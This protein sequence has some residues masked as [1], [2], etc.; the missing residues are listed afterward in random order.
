MNKT[1][2]SPCYILILLFLESLA[3]SNGYG[4]NPRWETNKRTPSRPAAD[5]NG[6]IKRCSS[7]ASFIQTATTGAAAFLLC[8][9]SAA[10]AK[11]ELLT[12]ADKLQAGFD[13]LNKE[14]SSIDRV[15]TK[16]AKKVDRAVTRKSAP[17]TKKIDKEVKKA[18]RETK[19]MVKKV[20]K[21][22]K[23]VMKKVDKKTEV[24]TNKAKKIGSA[25]EQKIGGGGGGVPQP[26]GGGID[27]SKL[28]VCKDAK[29]CL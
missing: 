14:V 8:N 19:K 27:V 21:E 18:T 28:K 23:V 7:R 13:S 16:E 6:I 17:M 29:G 4:V 22:T 24:V 5:D 11:T 25:V 26:K 12:T 15:L 3:S 2:G 9:P 10:I 1:R 20:D